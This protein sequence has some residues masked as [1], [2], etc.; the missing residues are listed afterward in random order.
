MTS[1]SKKH[2]RKVGR[3][4]KVRWPR[5]RRKTLSSLPLNKHIKIAT[6]YRAMTYENN[7]KTSR[8]LSTTKYIKK[9]HKETGR[10]GRD[11]GVHSHTL[12]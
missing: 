6:I 3:K 2:F 8:R 12:W 11:M 5:W 4:I 1:G 7:L 9:D 10:R